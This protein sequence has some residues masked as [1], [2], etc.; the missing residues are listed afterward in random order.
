[1]DF[2]MAQPRTVG[3]IGFGRF[4]QLWA[5][6]LKEDFEVR[7][8]DVSE[9]YSSEAAELGVKFVELRAA[10]EAEAVFYCVPISSFQKIFLQHANIYSKL[11]GAKVLIDT[12]SVKT[13]PKEVFDRLLPGHY[14]ALLTHPMFGPDS[15]KLNGLAGQTIVVD[16]YRCDEETFRFWEYYFASKKLRVVE[17]SADEHDRLAAE[18]QGVTHFVG[19]VLGEFGFEPTSIDTLGA[20]KLYEI[21]SQVCNDTWQLFVDL[22]TYNPYTRAMRIRLSDAQSKVFNELLPNRLYKDRLVVG[23]Q[24]GRGSFNEEAALYYLSRNPDLNYELKYLHTTENVLLELH[25]GFVDRGQF[26][27]HNSLGGIVRESV[28]AMSRYRCHIVEEFAIKI[29]HALMIAPN[30]DFSHVDTIMTHPQVLRQCRNNL[31]KKYQNLKQTS[32]EGDLVDHAKVAELLALGEIPTNVA[33]MGS[34]ALAQIYG[35]KMIE[36][37]LQDSQE[38]FT[39]FLWVERPH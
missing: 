12:L 7:V 36:D 32:G 17:M 38:N 27:M 18:S 15:V 2:H 8:H 19:R 30:A 34:K 22:Q 14:Q 25:E 5:S 35:L 39:S 23:I 1:M 13:H 16:R 24:G 26:A 10:L 11:S 33:T 4:G 20:K 21:K 9:S 37:E 28:D 3:I 6:I 29:S 31:D